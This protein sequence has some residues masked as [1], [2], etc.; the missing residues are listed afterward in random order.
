MSQIQIFNQMI[1]AP[2]LLLVLFRSWQLMYAI[3]RKY[4]SHHSELDS[5]SVYLHMYIRAKLWFSVNCLDTKKVSFVFRFRIS[6]PSIFGVCLCISD[7]NFVLPFAVCRIDDVNRI[8]TKFNWFLSFL[9]RLPS[10]VL[11]LT[12]LP[13]CQKQERG[14]HKNRSNF[15]LFRSFI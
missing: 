7:V 11:M 5:D 3:N 2:L 10:E 8:I 9:K 15:L 14:P 1:I 13:F 12:V 6:F 4:S